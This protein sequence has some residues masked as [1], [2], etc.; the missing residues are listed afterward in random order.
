MSHLTPRNR[1]ILIDQILQVLSDERQNDKKRESMKSGDSPNPGV[2][3]YTAKS[4]INR[5]LM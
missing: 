1:D 5:S 2:S 3:K 4:S